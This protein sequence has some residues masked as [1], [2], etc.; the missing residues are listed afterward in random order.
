[1]GQ[2]NNVIPDYRIDRKIA[3]GNTVHAFLLRVRENTACIH[4][5]IIPEEQKADISRY[6]F[7][8]DRDKHL[9]ARS[10]LYDQLAA[11]YAVT[12][13]GLDYT[14][15]KKPVLRSHPGIHFSFSYA[16]E[17][18]LIGISTGKKLGVNI[19]YIDRKFPVADTASS[20]LSPDELVSFHLYESGSAEQYHFFFRLFTAKEAIIK[21]FG[22]GL[23]YDVRK[24]NTLS[25]DQFEYGQEHFLYR[26]EGLWREEYCLAVCGEV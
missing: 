23:N 2:E 16:K 20:V 6:H 15:F 1:M 8:H 5:A 25:G 22:T 4:H 11:Q 7:Q 14:E 19:E 9:L 17:Y 12:D 3:V 13:F 21:A 26:D 24:I 10:F 18:V